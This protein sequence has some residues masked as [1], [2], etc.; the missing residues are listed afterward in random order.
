MQIEFCSGQRTRPQWLS[1]PFSF[2]EDE[3]APLR[4]STAT[5]NRWTLR[6]ACTFAP[7]WGT[8]ALLPPLRIQLLIS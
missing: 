3:R 2:E 8:E 4:T 1:D 6:V 7:Q 5:E